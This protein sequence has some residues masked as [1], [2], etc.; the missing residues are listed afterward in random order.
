[1]MNRRNAMKTIGASALGSLIL[2][3]LTFGSTLSEIGLQIYTVRNLLDQDFEGTIKSISNL[4]FRRLETFAGS[5]GH[6]W[7][8]TPGNLKN[9]FIDHD[10]KWI[11]MHIPL[12]WDKVTEHAIHFASTTQNI[13]KLAATAADLG[14][15]FL[16][17]PY[18]AKEDR[19]TIEQYKLIA[20]QLN[21][22]GSAC[23]S[24][25]VEF[26]YHNHDFELLPINGELPLDVLMNHTDP[27]LVKFEM[28]VYWVVKAGQNPVELM[29]KYPGR[30]KM[31]H[32]KDMDK[33][34]EKSFTEVGNG[35]ID[36]KTFLKEAQTAGFQHYFV[37][38]DK[39]PANPLISIE[40]SFKYLNTLNF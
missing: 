27:A 10:L 6:F 8:Y 38:Q 35:S 28:D 4:G 23:K 22:A 25:G 2:P 32:I 34:P 11:S 40:K 12:K 33:T 24:E 16:V 18:L 36:F 20:E 31:A 17:C 19:E 7:G 21:K 39:T 30:F 9:F 15:K 29:K 1:M 13:D 37:E 3:S 5:K 14:I 26:A